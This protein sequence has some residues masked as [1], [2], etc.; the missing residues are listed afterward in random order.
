M[1][2]ISREIFVDQEGDLYVC[3]CG[4]GKQDQKDRVLVTVR[5]GKTVFARYEDLDEE[6]KE[7]MIGIFKAVSTDPV[8]EFIKF[9]DFKED[10]DEFCA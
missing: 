10:Q 1:S 2:E 6:I 4:G 9:L 5:G 3:D 7:F 8:D